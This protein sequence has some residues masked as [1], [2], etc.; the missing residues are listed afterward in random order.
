M[1]ETKEFEKY[2]QEVLKKVNEKGEE[3]N[4]NNFNEFLE[5]TQ[6]LQF[7]QID[8]KMRLIDQMNISIFLNQT[9]IVENRKIVG[10]EVWEK[11]KQICLDN[12]LSY[13][14]RKIEL[15]KIQEI[16]D[17]FMY[18]VTIY[19]EDNCKKYFVY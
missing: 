8:K 7:K 9:I 3:Y 10:S 4:Q 15:S 19:D 1:L 5:E 17:L 16:M 12:Q 13:A 18:S 11:Y 6:T 2:Y 14:K